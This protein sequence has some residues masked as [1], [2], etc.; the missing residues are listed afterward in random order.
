MG[1]NFLPPTSV[2]ILSAW[3]L[4]ILCP[5]LAA[6]QGG[7]FSLNQLQRPDDYSS[8]HVSTIVAQD[9]V[10][11]GAKIPHI[12]RQPAEPTSLV[13]TGPMDRFI[14]AI[15]VGASVLRLSID[16]GSSDL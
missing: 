7:P 5:T 16:T 4:N 10:K 6:N 8:L 1:S 14:V 3:I 11:Y 13:E 9:L 15:N 12:I 2:L